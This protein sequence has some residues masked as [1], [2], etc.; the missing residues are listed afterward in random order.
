MSDKLPGA[1]GFDPKSKPGGA[2]VQSILPIRPV[3]CLLPEAAVLGGPELCYLQRMW[4]L[5]CTVLHPCLAKSEITH[6]SNPPAASV[7]SQVYLSR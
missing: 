7:R 2:R 1:A 4:S 6:Y 3:E 5:A